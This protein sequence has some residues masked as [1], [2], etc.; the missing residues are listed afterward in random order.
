MI[1]DGRYIYCIIEAGQARSFGPLGIGGKG[2]EVYTISFKDVAAVVSNAAVKRY[3]TSRENTMAHERAIEKVMEGH[4]VLPVRFATVAENEQKVKRILEVKQENFKNLLDKIRNKKE[5]GIKAVFKEDIIYREILEKYE[6][7]KKLK[8]LVASNP[9]EKT[10]YQRMEIGRMVEQALT[11]EKNK[12]EKV[13]LDTLTPL[14][15][16]VKI[17]NT[18]GERMILNAAFLV[19]EKKEVE[20][21]RMVA[22]LDASYGDKIKFKYVG[23]IPPFNF[24]NLAI[25]TEEF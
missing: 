13:I 19:N 24:V 12:A 17:N 7:I 11:N 16:D 9:P 14:A 2:D 18:Y 10:Y 21:D 25:N 3:P 5:L 15:E 23:I 8:I 22:E 20:F 6:K 1:I 4:T